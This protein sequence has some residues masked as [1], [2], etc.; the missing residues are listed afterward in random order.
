MKAFGARWSRRTSASFFCRERGNRACR[1]AA[2]LTNALRDR[3]ARLSGK[4]KKHRGKI[5]GNLR[6]VERARKPSDNTLPL[7]KPKYAYWLCK[8][9]CGQTVIERADNLVSG[10]VKSCCI[11]GHRWQEEKQ[12]EKRK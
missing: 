2:F 5:F 4:A 3:C 7:P 1:P 9:S 12:R 8:C 6:V 11:N 10:A